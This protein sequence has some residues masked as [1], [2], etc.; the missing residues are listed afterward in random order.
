LYNYSAN[1][2]YIGK[3]FLYL[4]CCHSTNDFAKQ[5]AEL[6]EDSHGAVIL[7]EA[8]TQGRGQQ[9]STW[10]SEPGQNLTFSLIVRP[11]ELN[12]LNQFLFN[13]V[14]SI[15]LLAFFRNYFPDHASGFNIKWPNDIYLYNK[16]IAG[17]LIENSMQGKLIRYSIVGIGL[18]VNQTSFDLP[19]ASSLALGLNMAI[20]RAA[21]FNALL[22]YLDENL[23]VIFHFSETEIKSI[24]KIYDTTLWKYNEKH[25][26]TSGNEQ[27]TGI[28]KGVDAQGKLRLEIEGRLES[29]E[30]KSLQFLNNTPN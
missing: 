21:L 16:K 25:Q 3:R 18:N 26:Y 22:T 2:Q 30:I 14:L 28:I 15:H 4:T 7:A 11:Q 24:E 10:K 20:D 6:R 12:T 17:L 29:F 23:P 5:F 9:G 19:Q 1:H 13:K 8:Q 27:F